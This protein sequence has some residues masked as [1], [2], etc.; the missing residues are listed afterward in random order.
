MDYYY[1]SNPIKPYVPPLIDTIEYNLY[2]EKLSRE[3]GISGA[4]LQWFQS[5]FSDGLEHVLFSGAASDDV[6]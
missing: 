3:Y 5:Y 1:Y 2:I 6:P 4:S